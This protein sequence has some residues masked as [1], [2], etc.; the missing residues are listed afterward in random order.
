[1]QYYHSTQQSILGLGP[2]HVRHS[3]LSCAPSVDTFCG[4]RAAPVEDVHPAVLPGLA[5]EDVV[6]E[7]VLVV[8]EDGDLF[9]MSLAYNSK[10]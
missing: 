10:K 5:L 7:L 1:M 6:E 2:E 3:G 8:P 4:E 9:L